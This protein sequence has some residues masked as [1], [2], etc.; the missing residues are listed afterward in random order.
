MRKRTQARESALKVMYQKEMTGETA[1]DSLRSFFASQPKMDLDLRDFVIKLVEGVENDTAALD[2]KVE[3][4][5]ENWSMKRMAVLD[6]NI[7]RIAMFE[8]TA[9]TETPPKVVINEAV[10]LAKK[11]SGE[12]SGKFVNG[13]LDKLMRQIADAK[14][15]S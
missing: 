2:Q 14:P 4:V 7:L 5:A 8:M 13:V 3:A 9:M 1:N 15:A 10:N 6:R 12:N 11:Y